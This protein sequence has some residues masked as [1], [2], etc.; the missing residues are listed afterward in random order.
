[1]ENYNV[2]M[3]TGAETLPL[4][5]SVNTIRMVNDEIYGYIERSDGLSWFPL[6]GKLTSVRVSSKVKSN[7]WYLQHDLDN[8]GVQVLAFD[9]DN[10]NISYNSKEIIDSDRISLEFDCPVEG[11]ALIFIEQPKNV[12][13]NKI[14]ISDDI[15]ISISN[16]DGDLKTV[17]L[18]G[19]NTDLNK[20]RKDFE[21]YKV[22]VNADISQMRSNYTIELN[23]LIES[24]RVLKS[25]LI[26]EFNS[27]NSRFQENIEEGK[28]TLNQILEQERARMT[29]EFDRVMCN[30]I[31]N[32]DGKLAALVEFNLT[33]TSL[34]KRV[35]EVATNETK[36]SELQG[37]VDSLENRIKEIESKTL[38][39]P[40]C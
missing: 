18:K 33:L 27:I 23:K 39:L 4:H 31:K 25:G 30:H 2:L 8:D 14:E 37:L 20:L 40:K 17:S 36:L 13:L 1:M 21:E 32:I 26:Q 10:K 34:E 35:D 12:K 15:I 28:V 29:Q 5:P 3:S 16:I 9:Q 24:N 19:M 7:T 11:F 6:T 22:S 38:C